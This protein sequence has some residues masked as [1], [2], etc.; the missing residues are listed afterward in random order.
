[1]KLLPL[2]S[3]STIDGLVK[4][5]TAFDTLAEMCDGGGRYR[6]TLYTFRREVKII[7]DAYDQY[8]AKR[9]DNRR[10]SRVTK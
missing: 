6:P 1:M 9:G 5:H 10:A 2:R 7:A 8:Q 3:Q 4:K